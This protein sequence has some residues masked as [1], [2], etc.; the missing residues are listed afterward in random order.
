MPATGRATN[1]GQITVSAE[2][3]AA[4]FANGGQPIREYEDQRSA[5]TRAEPLQIRA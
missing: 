3:A 4:L 1:A 2:L 5:L